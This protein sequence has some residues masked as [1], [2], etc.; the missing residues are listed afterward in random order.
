M[1]G[2]VAAPWLGEAFYRRLAVATLFGAA[3]NFSPLDPDQSLVLERSDQCG[4]GG[5]D[6][7]IIM[8]S[9]SRCDV[10]RSYSA[11]G[12]IRSAG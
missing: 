6:H 4:R 10:M 9:G 11:R 1:G 5:A 7:A 12:L 2:P 3:L 8:L